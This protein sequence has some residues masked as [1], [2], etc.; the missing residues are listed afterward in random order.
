MYTRADNKPMTMK[1]LLQVLADHKTTLK[2]DAPVT[3]SSDEEGNDMLKLYGIEVQR[4]KITLW[5]A[6]I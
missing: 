3:M 2:M 1:D 6:H 4:G 5:P